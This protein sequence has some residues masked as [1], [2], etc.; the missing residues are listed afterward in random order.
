MGNRGLKIVSVIVT[1]SI[2]TLLVFAGPAGAVIL[3]F[4]LNNMFV[5]LGKKANFFASTEIETGESLPITKFRIDLNGPE[6]IFCEFLANGTK[7]SDCNGFLIKQTSSTNNTLGYGYQSNCGYGYNNYGYQPCENFTKGLLGYNISFNTNGHM[8]GVYNTKYT[9]FIG[10]K[11][12]EK[13]GNNL[14]IYD[15][16]ALRGCSIRADDGNINNIIIGQE[17]NQGK[18]KLSLNIPLENAAFGQGSFIT[19]IKRE[20]MSYDFTV[21]G[22]IE[23]SPQKALILTKGSY[24]LNREQNKTLNDI[25]LMN[26]DKK[27]R[28]ISLAGEKIDISNMD[29]TLMRNC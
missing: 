25:V 5:E 13:L 29:I 26:L 11:K 4:N 23:N 3:K 22:V 14:F 19:Q 24:Q 9:L 21:L 16:T 20:R 7:V 18:N 1:F 10:N 8:T 2:I 27:N 28:E 15:R 17:F 6:N 12:T